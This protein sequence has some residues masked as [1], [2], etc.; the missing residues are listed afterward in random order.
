[1]LTYADTYARLGIPGILEARILGIL[2]RGI[3]GILDGFLLP[4]RTKACHTAN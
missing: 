1:M 2:E 3:P 4:A